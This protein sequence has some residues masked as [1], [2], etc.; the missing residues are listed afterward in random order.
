MTANTVIVVAFEVWPWPALGCYGHDWIATPGWD[1]FAA[2]GFV[3]DRAVAILMESAR[4][5]ALTRCRNAGVETILFT[6][7]GLTPWPGMWDRQETVAGDADREAPW[8]QHPSTQVFRAAIETLQRPTDRPR[9]IA[10]QARGWVPGIAPS[11]TALELYA[12]DFAAEGIDIAAIP[13]EDLAASAV[14]RAT[15]ISLLDHGVSLLADA[16]AECTTP[17]WCALVA[18]AGANWLSLTRS[19]PLPEVVDPQ[20]LLVPF[21]VWSSSPQRRQQPG[22]TTAP[23]STTDLWPS[24]TAWLGLV[25]LEHDSARDLTPLIDGNVRSLH[26]RVTQQV[27]G[28]QAGWTAADLTLTPTDATLQPQ[29]FYLPEDQWAMCDVTKPTEP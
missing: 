7:A 3:F 15:R 28:W 1:A 12:E 11:R 19:T 25:P 16:L 17:T 4:T 9:L 24:V 6:E 5:A 20:R 23:V 21:V 22:R 26:D 18:Q 29:R 10:I 2:S 14:G 27:D 13:D 8:S